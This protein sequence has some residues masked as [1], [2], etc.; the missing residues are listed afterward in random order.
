MR[1]KN[2]HICYQ[3]FVVAALLF[4]SLLVSCQNRIKAEA[5]VLDLLLGKEVLFPDSL[6]FTRYGADTVIYPVFSADYKILV[7]VDTVGC[8]SCRLQ[9]NKWLDWIDFL[10]RESTYS[11]SYLFYFYPKDIDELQN[12]LKYN[13]FD[14]PIC[15]D[16]E[17]LL[18]KLN[19]FPSQAKYNT[20]LLN[21]DNRIVLVG[22]P[23]N[24]VKV[25]DLYREV[26]IPKSDVVE[27]TKTE[28]NMVETDID[29]GEVHKDSIVAE[30]LIN[31][32]GRS[33]FCI[34]M[35]NV[36]CDCIA[37]EYDKKPVAPGREL[38]IKV[39]VKKERRGYFRE[40]ITLYCNVEDSPFYLT[41][42]GNA[43]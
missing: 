25:A 8:T 30:F 38:A 14:L 23:I 41:L 9:L 2:I 17:G 29:L 22:N 31:N 40:T 1:N 36:G 26:L 4:V 18:G 13:N 33:S 11:I 34:N 43:I 20:F 35:L 5:N 10:D 27:V 6:C 24:N 7:Y 3:L 16:H 28:V 21:A 12:V 15:I 42:R 39:K 32:V 37:A 19:I